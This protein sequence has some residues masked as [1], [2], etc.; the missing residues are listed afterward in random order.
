MIQICA[1]TG[2]SYGQGAALAAAITWIIHP[3]PTNKVI[4]FSC[5]GWGHFAQN[6]FT[7]PVKT[8]QPLPVPL[9]KPSMCEDIDEGIIGQ[10]SANLKL[11]WTDFVKLPA[12]LTPV[13]PN[14]ESASPNSSPTLILQSQVHFWP[15]ESDKRLGPSSLVQICTKSWNGTS[16]YSYRNLRIIASCISGSH[17]N[18][19]QVHFKKSPGDAWC[20]WCWLYQRN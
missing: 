2:P 4:C 11:M 19:K 18:L 5:G 16:S 10:T 13:L 14:N 8:A 12:G 9:T 17:D 7:A 20:H 1:D 3:Q 15:L 6:C